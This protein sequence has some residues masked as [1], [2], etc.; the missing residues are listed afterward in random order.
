M[1]TFDELAAARLRRTYSTPDVV[2][3]RRRTRERFGAA[4]GERLLDLG[5]GP[6]L[7]AVELAEE[8]GPDGHVTALDPSE[9]ML[10]IVR[11]EVAARDLEQRVTVRVGDAHELP[12]EAGTF[13]GVVAVQVLEHLD[14]VL[15]ALAEI[16]RVL[17]DEGR[18]V[19]IDTDWRTCLWESDDPERT[20]RVV[21]AWR[22]R[23]AG[24]DLPGRLP[25]LLETAGF[26]DVEVTGLPIV[27]TR[28]GGETYSQGMIGPIAAY[29]GD[30]A[31]LGPDVARAWREDVRAR[32][33]AGTDFFSLTR[34]LYVARPSS[35]PG[36]PSLGTPTSKTDSSSASAS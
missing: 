13:D 18:L 10:A 24:P 19:V 25:A 26:G 23:F 29:V 6:G 2:A 21:R 8:V 33:A 28:V 12:F 36:S 34:F 5:C 9:P 31:R 27:N 15:G 20:E 3:Q 17:R 4:P 7:L 14:D 16:R 30:E 11:E 22:S 1:A 35:D 32:L